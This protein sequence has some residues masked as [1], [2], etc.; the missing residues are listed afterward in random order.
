MYITLHS[1][2]LGFRRLQVACRLNTIKYDFKETFSFRI[3]DVAQAYET[4]GYR[5]HQVL[6][7]PRLYSDR[8]ALNRAVDGKR[9][10]LPGAGANQCRRGTNHLPSRPVGRL[11]ELLCNEIPFVPFPDTNKAKQQQK[12][13]NETK[14][15]WNFYT[16]GFLAIVAAA[17]MWFV[18]RWWV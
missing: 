4:L 3:G 13:F 2:A 9:P 8:A 18:M 7:D 17:V 5:T 6:A 10:G 14:A 1:L 16:R 15:G 11:R 12:K